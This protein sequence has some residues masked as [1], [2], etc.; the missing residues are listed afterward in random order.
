MLILKIISI[1][2][3][4]QR[5]SIKIGSIGV[6]NSIR[7]NNNTWTDSPEGTQEGW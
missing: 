6:I 3:D 4:S 7:K 1:W 5:I 2:L